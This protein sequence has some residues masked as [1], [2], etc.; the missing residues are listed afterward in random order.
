M[1]TTPPPAPTR[2][3]ATTKVCPAPLLSL[4]CLDKIRLPRPNL[5]GSD[6]GY[7]NGIRAS[8]LLAKIS[9]GIKNTKEGKGNPNPRKEVG[10]KGRTHLFLRVLGVAGTPIQSRVDFSSATAARAT[11]GFR[12][13]ASPQFLF[14]E[15]RVRPMKTVGPSRG[16][17]RPRSCP[18]LGSGSWSRRTRGSPG[19]AP[20]WAA[21]AGA[22]GHVVAPEFPETCTRGYLVC[23]VPTTDRVDVPDREIGKI[24]PIGK[25]IVLF[26]FRSNFQ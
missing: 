19:A 8:N 9:V 21:G 2:G 16:T 7:N 20:G 12:P 24:L 14:S 13:G 23:R 18:G 26:I 5:C 3:P 22:T 1:A 4:S 10:E 6:R 17:W 15:T 11:R 25:M